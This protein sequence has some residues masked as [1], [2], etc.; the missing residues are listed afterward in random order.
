MCAAAR[1]GVRGKR[2]LHAAEESRRGKIGECAITFGESAEE[3][4]NKNAGLMVYWRGRLIKC[5]DRVG[6][7]SSSECSTKGV[8]GVVKAD[9]LTPIS[10]KQDWQED[11]TGV[12]DEFHRWVKQMVNSY[13]D[14]VL[15]KNEYK[16]EKLSEEQKADECLW[17][18]CDNR[19]C[20]KWRRVTREHNDDVL[21]WAKDKSWFC[22]HLPEFGALGEGV[23]ACSIDRGQFD[24]E[25]DDEMIQKMGRHDTDEVTA[26]MTSMSSR[27][28]PPADMV[29][30]SSRFGGGNSSR[31]GQ[32]ARD[33]RR[34]V[35][36]HLKRPPTNE[37]P[38]SRIPKRSKI[39]SPTRDF[40]DPRDPRD[41]RDLRNPR[42][43]RHES[44][45]PGFGGASSS[46]GGAF[47]GPPG[48]ENS[49][50]YYSKVVAR[51]AEKKRFR[52][53]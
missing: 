15:Q 32:E 26:R 33:E 6:T 22:F 35:T 9:F 25:E 28:V 12:K 41:P 3:A 20:K 42:D 2:P 10:T 30:R 31:G 47:A 17:L 38:L 37:M 27:V 14:N 1:Q 5:Y 4:A 49:R 51:K 16:V 43:T 18:Q 48:Y 44:G 21:R 19:N 34:Q 29:P 11:A 36:G 13:R 40:R 23:D 50:E 52:Q 7:L 46:G 39:R 45:P 8:L 53:R 24:V